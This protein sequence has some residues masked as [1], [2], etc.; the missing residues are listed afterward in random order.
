[1]YPYYMD[2]TWSSCNCST[3][4]FCGLGVILFGRVELLEMVFGIVRLKVCFNSYTEWKWCQVLG[5]DYS[6]LAF[7]CADRSVVLHA[8]FGSYYSTRIPRCA[9]QHST[10]IVC[11][12][13]IISLHTG[14]FMTHKRKWILVNCKGRE[15]PILMGICWMAMAEW[16]GTWLMTG[17]HVTCF[18][19][20]LHLKCTGWIWNRYVSHCLKSICCVF[21]EVCMMSILKCCGPVS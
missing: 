5:E 1:M 21:Q 2:T 15:L 14:Y 18:L 6:K 13:H 3:H 16:E 4:A 11:Q 10:Q 12:P 8:K 17:G 9:P 7:L 19:P 20:L